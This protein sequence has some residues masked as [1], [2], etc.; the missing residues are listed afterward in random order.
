MFPARRVVSL[1]AIYGR[2]RDLRKNPSPESPVTSIS[3]VPGSGVVT[4]GP[5]GPGGSPGPPGE[6]GPEG[7]PG[8]KGDP[9][10]DGE[11]GPVGELVAGSIG[12]EFTFR[13]RVFVFLKR[14]RSVRDT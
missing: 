7:T 13:T 10:P 3:N 9:G 4:G 12:Y 5:S 14:P 11:P 1:A 2:L 8:T 6:S